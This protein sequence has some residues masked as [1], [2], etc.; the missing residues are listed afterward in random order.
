M[1]LTLLFVLAI[2]C[3]PATG[4]SRYPAQNLHIKWELVANKHK[5]GQFL[6]TLTFTNNATVTLPTT[7]WKLYFNLRYHGRNLTSQNDQLVIQHESGDLFY[8]AP[9]ERFQSLAAGKSFQCQFTGNR[10]VA[11]TYDTPA[12][13]FFVD[14]ANPGVAV[15]LSKPEL[16]PIPPGQIQPVMDAEEIFKANSTLQAQ[17]DP[18]N[19]VFPTPV[20]QV[21]LTSAFKFDKNTVIN[22]DPAFASEANYL[23]SETEKLFGSKALINGEKKTP[24]IE[25]KKAAMPAEAYRLSIDGSGIVI[26]ANDR[27]GMFYG[28]Q[29]LKSLLPADVYKTKQERITIN[30]IRVEDQPR[31]AVREFMLDVARNFQTKAE[32]LKVLEVMSLY[33]LNIFHFHLTDDEGWRLEIPGLPELT[34]IGS[35]RGYPYQ[36]NTQLHPAYGSGVEGSKTGQTGFYS[37]QDFLEILK[38]AQARH[39]TVIPEIE[40]PGHARAAIKSMEAR[41]QKYVKQGNMLEAKRYLLT[42][43]EDQSTYS[44]AQYFK[45]NVM[46]VALPST[47]A[48]IEKVIDEISAMYKDAGVPFK[49]IHM[50]GD[51]VPNGSWE[52]SPVV[53][54]FQQQNPA[55]TTTK[56]LW[57]YYFDQVKS[58]LA[59]RNLGMYGWQELVVGTQTNSEHHIIDKSFV[60][61]D[62]TL[63]AWWNLYGNEDIP[64]QLANAGYKTILTCFDYFYFDLA[65]SSSFQEPGDG[66]IGFLDID[67]GFGFIPFDY[68]RNSQTDIRGLPL[69]NGFYHDKEVLKPESRANILGLQGALWGENLTSPEVMEY[70]LLPRLHALA[71]RAWAPDPA[72]ASTTDAV[73]AD[74]EFRSDWSAFAT[75]TARELLKLDY[76]GSYHYRIPAPGAAVIDGKVHANCQLPGFVIRYTTNGKEP[77]VSDKIYTAPFTANGN[78]RLRAFNSMGRGSLTTILE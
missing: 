63:D 20:K 52:K 11:N 35:K 48:F 62:V 36:E 66:W 13:F 74:Q 41:Y 60:N 72:W 43:L 23:A 25:L 51:E 53:K 57:R 26:E 45:D 7:G 56:D 55:I 40:A 4:Q 47:Y 42:D 16:M 73:S 17:V 32:I 49:Q 58:I 75:K 6:A 3:Q 65:Y 78:I 76:N 34:D 46:N 30:G 19:R 18:G 33:K 71:E 44:S 29:S 69:P 24:T 59:K 39:I 21:A 67:K 8:I 64:Y 2:I 37:R 10:I 50:A 1:R 15:P 5:E 27:A 22:S 12:G 14:L 61:A 70:L 38:Y 28:I 31:F 9:T 68:Y 77:S 54:A